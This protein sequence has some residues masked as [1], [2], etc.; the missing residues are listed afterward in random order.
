MRLKHNK[1]K[2]EITDSN[3]LLHT[4]LFHVEELML[5]FSNGEERLYER[6]NPGFDRAVMV[7]PVLDRETVLLVRE[8]GAGLEDYYLS[9]PKGAMDPQ[10]SVLET[11]NRELKEEIGYGARQLRFLKKLHLSP[12][13]MG[14]AINLVLA[15]SL[16][17][18]RL[19]GDE[20]EPLDVIPYPIAEIP[21]LIEDP[22]CCEA[23]G[24]AALLMLSSLDLDSILNSD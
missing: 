7:I 14:N 1:Q 16:Y 11:A 5:R 4:R 21:Q 9:F 2:P 8:Y 6:L 22:N 18:E 10:E 20:P 13:Y 3:W 15:S 17:E 12:S 23:Y 19:P 24:V